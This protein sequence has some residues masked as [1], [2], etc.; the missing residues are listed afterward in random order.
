[1]IFY[2]KIKDL[3]YSVLCSPGCSYVV[4]RVF[5]YIVLGY[6]NI[7]LYLSIFDKQFVLNF[8]FFTLNFLVKNS[9]TN[10]IKI[11]LLCQNADIVDV[12]KK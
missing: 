9:T 1:M 6:V 12:K 8:A 11:E 5:D 10:F 2:Q 3:F 4:Q 7:R